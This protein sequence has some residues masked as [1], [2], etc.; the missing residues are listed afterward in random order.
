MLPLWGG[1]Q[2]PSRNLKSNQGETMSKESY[3]RGFCKAAEAAGVDPVALAKYASGKKVDKW[4]PL[5]PEGFV[6]GNSVSNNTGVYHLPKPIGKGG[7]A[8]GKKPLIIFG[9]GDKI[10]SLPSSASVTNNPNAT[11]SVS[12]QGKSSVEPLWKRIKRKDGT[13]VN[14]PASFDAL[15]NLQSL[16]NQK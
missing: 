2:I 8:A 7:W 13:V 15:I 14:A 16:A 11:Y 3:A 1:G 10:T 9:P 4:N 6:A 12:R 5:G